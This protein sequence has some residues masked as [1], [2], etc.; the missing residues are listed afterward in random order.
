MVMDGIANLRL[1]MGD[2]DGAEEAALSALQ[3][4]PENPGLIMRRLSGIAQGRGDSAK[5]LEWAE[6]AIAA[7]P[8]DPWTHL[9]HFNL[10]VEED[11]IS[12]AEIAFQNAMAASPVALGPGPASWH[13]ARDAPPGFPICG[14]MG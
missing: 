7:S 5:A 11:Q 4:S 1:Q 9:V 3:M 13:Q 10:L 2:I 12:R 14:R 8:E 6:R